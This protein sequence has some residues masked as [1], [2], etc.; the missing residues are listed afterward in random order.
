MT[1]DVDSSGIVFTKSQLAD[2]SYRW[3]FIGQWFP[4]SDNEEARAFYCVC[5]LVLLKPWHDL[6][7]DLKQAGQ[8]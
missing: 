4:R 7:N 5:M 3:N 6:G 8:M 2:Y 1:L